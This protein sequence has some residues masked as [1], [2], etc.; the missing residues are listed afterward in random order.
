MTL[1]IM[2]EM[3]AIGAALI[4]VLLMWHRVQ[5]HRRIRELDIRLTRMQKEIEALQIQ[6][7]RRVMVALKANSKVDAPG[8]EPD[9][10]PV[11]SGDINRANEGPSPDTRRMATPLRVR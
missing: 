8:I 1:M 6:E 9:S 3:A 5:I 11:D 4:A 10:D 7:S 2:Y